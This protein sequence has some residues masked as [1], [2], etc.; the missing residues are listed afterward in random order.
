MP[1]ASLALRSHSFAKLYPTGCVSVREEQRNGDKAQPTLIAHASTE[2]EVF[3]PVG[4]FR[5]PRGCPRGVLF[6]RRIP[7][8]SESVLQPTSL[9]SESGAEGKLLSR[10][11]GV[12]VPQATAAALCSSCRYNSG[13]M[14]AEWKWDAGSPKKSCFF[15]LRLWRNSGNW[16]TALPTEQYFPACN[17]QSSQKHKVK[18]K[19]SVDECM[20]TLY[21]LVTL[22]NRNKACWQIKGKN[23][24]VAA[25]YLQIRKFS[26]AVSNSRTAVHPGQNCS[27]NKVF[28][29]SQSLT[30]LPFICTVFS[31][32][33]WDKSPS[34]N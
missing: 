17:S 11:N 19:Y 31:I 21:M 32:S 8:L 15:P 5:A 33:L 9:W 23:L 16:K 30:V 20:W 1:P 3:V 14:R 29:M 6:S 10:L 34:A 26:Q 22:Q 7:C 28:G 27:L 18:L 12:F 13:C 24:T 2:K 4:S 25:E